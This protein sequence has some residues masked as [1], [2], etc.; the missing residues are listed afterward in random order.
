MK[1]LVD[2]G[3]NLS[4]ESFAH[5]REDVIARAIAAGVDT[6][7]ITGT[8]VEGSR[9]AIAVARG[10][11]PLLHATVG[12]HPHD[13]EGFDETTLLTLEGLAREESV[14]SLGECGLDY[15]RDYSPRHAQRHAFE[16]Q[17]DLA[18]RTPLPVF[19]HE[20]DA[21]DDMLAMLRPVRDRLADAVIHCF[22]GTKDALHRYLDLGLYIGITGWIC[23]ERRG[24]HLREFVGDIPRDRLMI[25]TDAPYLL[26]RTIRPMPKHRRNEPCYLPYVVTAIAES[27][28]RAPEDVAHETAETARRFFRLPPA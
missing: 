15:H 21:T 18:A 26:P 13:S 6:M 5:D 1:G 17:L 10:R 8:S 9:A 23:D 2:V 25:E 27:T 16:A 12:V 14:V 7:I 3:A 20:R 22:T 11:S 28:G 19:L 24:L 4:H